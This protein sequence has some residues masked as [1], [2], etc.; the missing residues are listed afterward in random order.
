MQKFEMGKQEQ[1]IG[2]EKVLSSSRPVVKGCYIIICLSRLDVKLG[3]WLKIN[4]IVI[5]RILIKTDKT[6]CPTARTQLEAVCAESCIH[7]H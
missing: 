3:Y 6:V 5:R 2:R 7:V 1:E 4:V